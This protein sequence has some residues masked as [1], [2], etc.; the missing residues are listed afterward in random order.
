MGR[1]LSILRRHRRA[2]LVCTFA[3]TVML[4]PVISA[5][6]GPR[7]KLPDFS[8]L[9]DKATEEV[10]ISLDTGLLG[11]AARFMDDDDGEQKAVKDLLANLKGIYV[12][13]FEFDSA[14]QYNRA[15]LDAIRRQFSDPGW[16]RQVGVRSR[17]EGTN[18]DIYVWMDGKKPGGIAVLAAEP[19]QLTI[20]NL[21]GAIDLDALRRLDGELGMPKLDLERKKEEEQ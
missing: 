12:R 13:S 8:A 9:A 5:A 6:Q 19:R 11:L 17:R 10:D 3:L 18:V 1:H 20:V 2:Q 16:H 4:V 14:G 15:D 7:L 21:I